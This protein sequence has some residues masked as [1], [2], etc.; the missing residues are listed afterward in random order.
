MDFVFEILCFAGLL[1]L[2][3]L[4]KDEFLPEDFPAHVPQ[5]PPLPQCPHLE[6]LVQAAQLAEPVHLPS[7]PTLS[8]ALKQEFK[9][10]ALKVIMMKGISFFIVISLVIVL[11]CHQKF[12]TV[13]INFIQGTQEDFFTG[14]LPIME[15]FKVFVACIEAEPA[16]RFPIIIVQQNPE[17]R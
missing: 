15:S 13:V 10:N 4:P 9:I 1:L 5:V 12:I 16:D 17:V 11:Q 7:W 6:Q 3:E 14:F 2:K 8:L